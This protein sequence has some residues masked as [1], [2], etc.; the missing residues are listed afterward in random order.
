[1]KIRI[2]LKQYWLSRLT[3]AASILFGL[4]SFYFFSSQGKLEDIAEKIENEYALMHAAALDRSVFG[5]EL[6]NSEFLCRNKFPNQCVGILQST[7]SLRNR[8]F[9][10][11]E[12]MRTS[13]SKES[14]QGLLVRSAAT[15]EQIDQALRLNFG[16]SISEA[17][18]L[19][20]TS[21]DKYLE[22][23]SANRLH[24]TTFSSDEFIALR[25][26]VDKLFGDLILASSLEKEPETLMARE[27]SIA[28]IFL[29]FLIVL[30]ISVYVMFSYLSNRSD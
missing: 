18:S 10:Y 2:T 14:T 15:R 22:H 19:G 9:D 13:F 8:L 21:A 16:M 12:V 20:I 26:A 11:E 27:I 4:N 24:P 17:K 28:R 29:A 7:I 5:A 3:L 6:N 23:V 25:V 1:M 30:E